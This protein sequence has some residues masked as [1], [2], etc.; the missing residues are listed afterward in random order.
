VI[1]GEV[2]L[3]YVNTNQDVADILRKGLSIEKHTQ[4][5]EM[6]GVIDIDMIAEKHDGK[7]D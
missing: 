1:E 3:M 4:S 2:D 5:C 6:M 7:E